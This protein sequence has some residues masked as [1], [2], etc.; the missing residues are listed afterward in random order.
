[1]PNTRTRSKVTH[2]I[3]KIGRATSLLF[4]LKIDTREMDG[5]NEMLSAQLNSVSGCQGRCVCVTQKWHI[6]VPVYA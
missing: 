1:M 6:C 3:R 5:T 4:L 2:H